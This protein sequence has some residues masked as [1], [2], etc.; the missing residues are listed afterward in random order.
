[1]WC[2]KHLVISNVYQFVTCT[3]IYYFGYLLRTAHKHATAATRRRRCGERNKKK[4]THTHE[5]W[6][7]YWNKSFVKTAMKSKTVRQNMVIVYSDVCIRELARAPSRIHTFARCLW[8]AMGR[9]SPVLIHSAS[10]T[11]LARTQGTRVSRW[12]TRKIIDFH[13][14]VY[15]SKYEM[16][17]GLL[18][19]T[20]L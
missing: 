10:K 5:K 19:F 17:F 13:L 14:Q 8:M 18:S 6:V 1:M 4:N 12:Q 16:V 3:I 11:T 2:F 7:I 9:A 15:K 20:F